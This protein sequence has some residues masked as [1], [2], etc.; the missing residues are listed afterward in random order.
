M[1]LASSKL[2]KAQVQISKQSEM[3][4]TNLTRQLNTERERERERET[5]DVY[6]RETRKT[7]VQKT[8]RQ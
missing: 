3:S 8:C 7:E 6:V 5:G 2:D 4:K 1:S